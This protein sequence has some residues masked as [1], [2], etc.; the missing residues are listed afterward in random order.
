MSKFD[1]SNVEKQD[2]TAEPRP[3][4]IHE[5]TTEPVIHFRPAT[6]ANLDYWNEVMRRADSGQSQKDIRAARKAAKKAGGYDPA[7]AKQVQA[8]DAAH[9]AKF[10]ATAWD[11][12]VDASGNEVKFSKSA[13]EAFLTAL[14]GYV[15][16]RLRAWITNPANFVERD[17]AEDGR[18]VGKSSPGD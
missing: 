10:C 18:E 16:D 1:F 7:R 5:L 12:V 9:F 14:P 3:F 17:P 11:D 13:C 8:D 4:E 15:F 6:K 2:Q